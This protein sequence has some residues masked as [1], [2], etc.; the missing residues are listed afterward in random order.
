[1]EV[2]CTE[3]IPSVRLPCNQKVLLWSIF[4]FMVPYNKRHDDFLSKYFL[5]KAPI[6]DYRTKV[7]ES[8][9]RMGFKWLHFGKQGRLQ[10]FCPLS[11]PF[12]FKLSPLPHSAKMPC[13]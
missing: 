1:M 11:A 3:S 7:C 12:I 8:L 4:L 9:P 6:Q 13:L 10:S 2:R 5:V